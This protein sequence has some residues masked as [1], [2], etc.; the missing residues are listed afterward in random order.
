MC[1]REGRR[2]REGGRREGGRERERERERGGEGGR[3]SYTAVC[4]FI[5]HKRVPAH[6]YSRDDSRI[7][8][9]VDDGMSLLVH[10][11]VIFRRVAPPPSGSSNNIRHILV[12]LDLGPEGEIVE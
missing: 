7:N 10:H 5:S 6:L 1:E 3:E 12:P 2:R 11:N 8:K 9:T 4:C